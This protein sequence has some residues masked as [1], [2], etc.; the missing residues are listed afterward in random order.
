[1]E[2]KTINSEIEE[3]KK[4][5]NIA[6]GKL[7]TFESKKKELLKSN[8][9][10][11][12]QTIYQK[13]QDIEKSYNEVLREAEQRLK[14]VEKEKEEEKKRNIQKEIEH[15][16]RSIK[17]NNIFLNNEIK[18]LLKENKLPSFV[19]S[20]FY[21][22]IWSPS[23]AIEVLCRLLVIIL[24]MAIPTII[25]F[26]VYKNALINAFPNTFLRYVVIAMIYLIF[27]FVFGL[28][29]LLVDKWTKRDDA[30]FKEIKE[31]RKNISD[32]KKQIKEIADNTHKN[33]SDEKY[34]YTKLD[35]EIEAGK[36]EV[37]N[38]RKKMKDALDNFVNVTQ[39]EITKSVEQETNKAM[40]ILDNDI[41]TIKKEIADLQKKYDELKLSIAENS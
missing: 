5:L 2:E 35:R 40:S 22:T 21:M 33:M 41:E 25:T 23:N 26:F 34:D 1:M 12:A 36:L 17:E 39:D 19:N 3:L 29:W 6:K 37:E 7:T 9:D 13:K 11:I 24:V 38:Y 31:L 8:D 27:I 15:N 20:S 4:N 32:N 28:I 14:A 18:R 16:T 30:I 10:L